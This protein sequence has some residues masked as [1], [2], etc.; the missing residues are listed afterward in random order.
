MGLRVILVLADVTL[1]IKTVEVFVVLVLQGPFLIRVSQAV[2]AVA[3]DYTE[4]DLPR[5][6]A[7]PVMLGPFRWRL[8]YPAH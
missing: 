1:D 8:D 6:V 4:L 3:W 5:L 7:W 2:K